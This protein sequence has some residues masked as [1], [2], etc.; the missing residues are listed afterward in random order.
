MRYTAQVWVVH[1]TSTGQ[2]ITVAN[3]GAVSS[4]SVKV[5]IQ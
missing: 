2:M 4:N 5:A 3:G 1:S